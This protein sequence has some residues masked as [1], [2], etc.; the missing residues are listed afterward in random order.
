[1]ASDLHEW[2]P[3]K[4]GD[5][6]PE[7]AVY[8]GQ[9]GGD[10]KVYIAKMDNSAGKV[11]LENGKIHNFWSQKY[12]PR[13][14]GEVLISHGINSWKTLNYG[15]TIPNGAISSGIDYR[16]DKVWVG[17]DITT[18]EPGKIT[19]LNS[20]VPSPTMCKLWCHSY[21][22]NANVK[23]AKILI[24]EPE[25]TPEPTPAPI[26]APISAPISAPAPAPIS[27]PAPAPIPEPALISAPI[28]DSDW[29][30]T[31][32]YKR[33]TEYIKI[34]KL[35]VSVNNIVNAVTKTISLAAGDLTHITDLLKMDIELNMESTQIDCEEAEKNV[36]NDMNKKCYIMLKY[37]KKS[38]K[39]AGIFSGI[40]NYFQSDYKFIIE[41]AIFYPE[42]DT[43]RE[44]CENFKRKL[45][46]K[47]M[48]RFTM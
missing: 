20:E 22:S 48:D 35:D 18:D 36:I 10:G 33:K 27:A 44:K 6:I 31:L 37:Y 41:Y 23:K 28:D 5:S 24:I 46:D 42:N 2:I 16:N 4:R 17:K 7:N 30:Q 15:E 19:C 1:M 32:K 29:G 38:S 13:T 26:P 3:M 8:S 43:S 40:F 45:A 25:P 34:R 9:T 47:I 21:W 39:T 11:N 12:S 14:Q